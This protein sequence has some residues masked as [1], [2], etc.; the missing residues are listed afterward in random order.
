VSYL[1]LPQVGISAAKNAAVARSHGEVL[2]FVNDDVEP[3]EDFVHQHAVAQ[4]A[5]H[6]VVLGASPWRRFDD[7]RVFDECVA[8]TR[9]IFFY[10]DLRAGQCCDFRCA[11]NLNL[12]V[13]R[14]LLAHQAG[15]F[16]EAL[17]P[18]MYEDV[19]LAF[20]LLGAEKGVFYH[21][22][23]RAEH[24]HRY[25]LAGYFE[26]EAM[27]GVMARELFAVNADCFRAIFGCDLAEL[28]DRARAGLTLDVRDGRRCLSQTS[29]AAREPWVGG[30]QEELV[31]MLYAAH[32]PLK[33]RAFRCGLQAADD[34]PQWPWNDRSA[35]ASAALGN[36]PAFSGYRV[37]SVGTMSCCAARSD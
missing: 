13:R 19:E 15:P 25:R 5:G 21:P 28:V 16:A 10:E 1:A 29:R 18:C 17:R 33:R 4:S 35:L 27:L 14:E 34:H 8:R 37:G 24:N 6:G 7:Q 32:L 20:R 2:I 3:A 26:R 30:E 22:A 31:Q 11:W 23:A 36:D 9:M 12:S